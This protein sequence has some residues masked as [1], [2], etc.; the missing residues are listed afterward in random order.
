M[1][2]LVETAGRGLWKHSF[3]AK[4]LLPP[5]CCYSKEAGSGLGSKLAARSHRAPIQAGAM[6]AAQTDAQGR[7]DD[8]ADGRRD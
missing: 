6:S 7:I 4:A 2:I 3:L 5:V 8:S 1:Q